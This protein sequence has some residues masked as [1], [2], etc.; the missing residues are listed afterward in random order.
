MK[1]DFDIKSPKMELLDKL[2]I[3]ADQKTKPLGA[4]G[5]LEQLAIKI[6]LIQQSQTPSLNKPHI[7][8][9]AGDHGIS[10][11]GVSAY[12]KDVTFQMV[13]N[14]L[15]GGA[16]IN[17]LATQN[18]IDL[19][20]VDAGVDHEF[21]NVPGL[22]DQK[23]NY[24]TKN[25]LNNQAMTEK[26]LLL[27]IDKGRKAVNEV[28][29]TGCNIIGFGEMGIGNTSS[30]SLISS[31]ICNIRLEECIGRGTGI[32]NPGL[33]HKIDILNRASDYHKAVSQPL[34]VLQTFG[35]Y[36][37]VQLF[38]AMLQAAENG[39]IVLV[40]GFIATSAFLVAQAI[41][42]AIKSYSIM[43]HQS[44]EKGHQLMTDYL[45]MKPLLNLNMR[46]GE[47]TGCAVA[48]PIVKSAITFFNEMASFEAAG[49]S[50][51][52]DIE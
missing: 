8:V 47:G 2:K 18:G 22:I 39:M 25:F 11:D 36:E 9:F 28:H 24:G 43:C 13:H 23:I 30:A 31:R 33:Q 48:Y 5:R 3:K 14:F 45:N 42:P 20:I 27:A 21:E 44:E 49:V 35:G 16:A 12:P 19:L 26:E 15:A 34:Q 37:I 17:V 52:S 51:K 50:Q 29:K 32:D 46:L 40:D 1:L 7:I 6:G 4:L 38:G 41:Y 10:D